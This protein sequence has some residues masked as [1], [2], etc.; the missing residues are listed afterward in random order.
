MLAAIAADSQVLKPMAKSKYMVWKLLWVIFYFKKF[1]FVAFKVEV[2]KFSISCNF[3]FPELAAEF[4]SK[5]QNLEILEGEKAEFVCSIS[6]ESFEVQ[7][8]RDDNTLE[9]GDKYDIIA[10]GKKRTLVVKDATL[11]DMGTYVVMVGA[12]RAAAHLTVIGK[13]V[14]ASRVH[15]HS[16]ST[17][18]VLLHTIK[19]CWL[20]SEKL[21][22]IVPLKDT[23]VKEQQ[24]VVF[25]CEVNTEGAKAKWF[26]NEEAIFDS[27]K[28]II[29]QKDLVYT[30]RIRD[31]RLDDQ[32]NYNVSLTNHRG[33]N[34][35]SAANLI[36]EGKSLTWH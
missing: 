29:L 21:R 36:V 32:A 24:E 9:S 11:Q 33:E 25:N 12:A 27:S 14:F 7:W 8:K 3:F 22:I 2:L 23:R 19:S 17:T 5:P 20:L 18:L 6:K 1:I 16:L 15:S 30:L 13:F 31:A 34:V 35:K 10:D 4:I 26:R 28:Y